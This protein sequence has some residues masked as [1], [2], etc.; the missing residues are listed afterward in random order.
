MNRFE[1]CG[2]SQ[3]DDE[4]LRNAEAVSAGTEIVYIL[5]QSE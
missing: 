1:V 3:E 5:G 2:V 4:S